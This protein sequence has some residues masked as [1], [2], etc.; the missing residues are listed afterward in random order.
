MPAAP[1][2]A[3]TEYRQA[4]VTVG[5]GPREARFVFVP[6]D[7]CPLEH[8]PEKWKPV[9]RLREAMLPERENRFGGR[10][11]VGSDHAQT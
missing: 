4:L 9:S 8:D 7:C 5:Q 2:V 6:G 3:G 10:S 11:K 1:A